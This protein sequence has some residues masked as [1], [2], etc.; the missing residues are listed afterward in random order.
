M[1]TSQ[2]NSKC[3]QKKNNT[4]RSKKIGNALRDSVWDSSI[5]GDIGYILKKT[6]FFFFLIHFWQFV[7]LG[8]ANHIYSRNF[9]ENCLSC[10]GCLFACLFWG[11]VFWFGLGFSFLAKLRPAL[12]RTTKKNGV[13]VSWFHTYADRLRSPA[14]ND[15]C[16]MN[17][18]W[19]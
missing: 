2:V 15:V 11:R 5:S 7:S 14:T 19:D 8:L 3:L 13:I 17:K 16:H 9:K 10:F 4:W 12:Q 1:D 18:I 6:F